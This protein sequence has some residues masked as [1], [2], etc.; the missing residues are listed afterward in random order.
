M[1]D[2]KKRLNEPSHIYY[3]INIFN[4]ISTSSDA[5]KLE[6]SEARN[7]SF[8]SKAN[9]YLLSIVRFQM[10]TSSLPNY[11]VIPQTGS[12]NNLVFS[13]TVEKITRSTGAIVSQ[14]QQYLIWSPENKNSNSTNEDYYYG[15]SL[16]YFTTLINNAINSAMIAIDGSNNDYIFCNYNVDDSKLEVYGLYDRTA[17]NGTGLHATKYNLYFNRELQS[18]FNT[19]SYD[20]FLSATN[21]KYYRVRFDY[22][23]VNIK[24]HKNLDY[25]INKQQFETSSN[26]SP[27]SSICFTSSTLPCVYN[28][29]SNPAIYR[30]GS[31]INNTSNSNFFPIITD[32]QVNEQFYKSNVLYVPNAQYRY[33]DLISNSSIN[34]ID[35]QCYW[36][37]KSGFF[38]PIYLYSGMNASLKILFEK[39]ETEYIISTE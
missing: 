8:V 22:L 9:D 30:N 27:V 12:I 17:E 23:N 29:L 11:E 32:F 28:Q 6:F 16:I 3:D 35:I 4:E 21:G 38:H 2:L 24:T 26:I 13:I 31:K 10:D 15:N 34:N 39:K 19:L 20:R 7:T 36:R 33:I 37:D 18:W 25:I 5:V 1:I 14:S